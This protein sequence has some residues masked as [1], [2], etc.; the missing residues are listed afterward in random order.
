MR[1]AN[2]VVFGAALSPF[3]SAADFV[4]G[5]R[6]SVDTFKYTI[7]KCTDAKPCSL[8]LVRLA[9]MERV[10]TIFE[11]RAGTEFTAKIQNVPSGTYIFQATGGEDG[12]TTTTT[13]FTDFFGH[14]IVQPFSSS[15]TRQGLIC[16]W[17]YRYVGSLGSWILTAAPTASLSDAAIVC[18]VGG[19]FDEKLCSWNIS[20]SRNVFE[21]FCTGYE[22]IVV[23]ENGNSAVD[24]SKCP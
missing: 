18:Q 21:K 9:T 16:F 23:D 11:N 1:F 2:V 12:K 8:Y 15:G 7:N 4:T 20:D 3:A 13:Q 22:G 5:S 17:F 6:E 14:G 19:Q 10:A 24:D